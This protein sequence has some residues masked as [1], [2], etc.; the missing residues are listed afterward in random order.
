MPFVR[1]F[2][3]FGECDG[4]VPSVE[5]DKSQLNSRHCTLEIL[6]IL[7]PNHERLVFSVGYSDA[8]LPEYIVFILCPMSFDKR[9]PLAF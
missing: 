4:E 3:P 2:S 5:I 1:A 6:N 7:L 9:V 8:P